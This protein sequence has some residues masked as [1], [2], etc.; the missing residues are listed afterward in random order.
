M[1]RAYLRGSLSL[2]CVWG[3]GVRVGRYSAPHLTSNATLYASSQRQARMGLSASLLFPAALASKLTSQL[4]T[5][6]VFALHVRRL[7]L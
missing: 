5:D 2:A 4:C 6:G 7:L 1:R 3:I